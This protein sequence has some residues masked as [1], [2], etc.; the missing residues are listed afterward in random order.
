MNSKTSI[1]QRQHT[2]QGKILTLMLMLLCLPAALWAAD[3]D[4][5][6]ITISSKSDWNTFTEVY[7]D[8]SV[9]VKLNCNLTLADND[10]VMKSFKGTF[11][12]QG[13]TLTVRF[14]KNGGNQKAP[15]HTAEG[16]ICNLEITG[17]V[18]I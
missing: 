18:C 5:D 1:Q 12:G 17:S 3:A 8:S 15:F 14:T 2:V 4:T 16:T 13:H 6:T 10:K 11:D 9:Y 7:N